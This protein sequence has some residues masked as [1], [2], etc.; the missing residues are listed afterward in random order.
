[1]TTFNQHDQ[2]IP[3]LTDI[4]DDQEVGD[5]EETVAVSDAEVLAQIEEEIALRIFAELS[6]QIPILIEAALQKQVPQAIGAK[7]QSE[8]MTAFA[9][10]VPAA[11]A[12]ASDQLI[13]SVAQQLA[14]ELETRLL[15]QVRVVVAEEFS[16]LQQ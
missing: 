7:L 5:T 8:L 9:S 11:T 3:V 16:R 4:I 14:S 13:I 6:V 1:M 2:D 10:V 15:D 12:A